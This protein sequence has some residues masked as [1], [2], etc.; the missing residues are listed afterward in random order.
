MV[1]IC[2]SPCSDSDQY[3]QLPTCQLY[4]KNSLVNQLYK[5]Q[6]LSPPNL[7]IPSMCP[8]LVNSKNTQFFGQAS[9][10]K[11]LLT[12]ILQLFP[13]LHCLIALL[14]FL[15]KYLLI[16]PLIFISITITSAQAVKCHTYKC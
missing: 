14:I 10:F 7:V 11:S 9:I 4:L 16:S 5:T 2:I 15:S 12:P 1:Y 13:Q 8:V 3:I 6:T